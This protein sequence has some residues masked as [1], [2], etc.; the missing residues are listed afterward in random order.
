MPDKAGAGDAQP[1]TRHRRRYEARVIVKQPMRVAVNFWGERASFPFATID[2]ASPTVAFVEPPKLGDGDR[3][4]FKYK[5]ADDYG[6]DKL[7]F[8]V[9][10]LD[11]PKEAGVVE[12][13]T[14]VETVTLSPKE[15]E[16][17]SARISVK[18]RWAGM[19][20]MVEL[21]ATDGAGQTADSEEVAYHLPEKIFLQPNARMAQE[22]RRAAAQLGSVQDTARRRQIHRRQRHGL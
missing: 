4:E 6:V 20:V 19:D 10:R 9:R 15:E 17:P 11:T 12:D 1:R 13:P 18:H 3:T 2:D 8:I 21:R 14:L 16:A 5:L 7:E 22:A